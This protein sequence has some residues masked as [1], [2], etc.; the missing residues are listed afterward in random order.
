MVNGEKVALER[1]VAAYGRA[2]VW[3]G[4]RSAAVVVGLA[5][6]AVGLHRTS[7]ATWLVAGALA[8]ALGLLGW[9]GGAWKRGAMAGVLAGLPPLIAPSV[10]FAVAHGG[11]CATC[12][13]GANWPCM[14]VCFGTGSLVGMLVGKRAVGDRAPR[15]FAA[16]AIAT[17]AMTGMLG[18]GTT[19]LGGAL[20][21]GVGLVVGGLAGWLVAPR[22]VAA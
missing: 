21:I 11:H 13:Q 1:A 5:V 7:D 12:E 4:L 6:L 8:L 14:L 18:C 3:S 10:V 9:R 16:A 15:R 17:A 2:W 20:G 19:G 22:Q